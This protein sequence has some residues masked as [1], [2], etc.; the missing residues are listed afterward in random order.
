MVTYPSDFDSALSKIYARLNTLETNTDRLNE[1]YSILRRNLEHV[2]INSEPTS[3]LPTIKVN[4]GD[5]VFHARC[6]IMSEFCLM[7]K[8]IHESL[9]LWRPSKGGEGISL[10]NNVVILPLGIA[11]GVH[12]KILGGMISIDYLV[13]YGATVDAPKVTLPVVVIEKRSHGH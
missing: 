1:G 6:D 8:R 2:A 3:Y 12:T 7:P 5:K 10:A 13:I 4:I 11:E 9:T